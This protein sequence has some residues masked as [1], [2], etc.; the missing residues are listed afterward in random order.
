MTP[1][2]LPSGQNS[3]LLR[4]G[5]PG[6]EVAPPRASVPAADQGSRLHERRLRMLRDITAMLASNL[7]CDQVLQAITDAGRELTGAAFGAFLVKTADADEEGCRPQF[8]SGASP[9][10]F[11]RT[12]AGW[13]LTS[14][15][16]RRG[17]FRF[18]GLE[19]Q[20]RR[21]LHTSRTMVPGSSSSVA[22]FLAAPFISGAAATQGV[23]RFGHG[24]TAVFSNEADDIAMILASLAT[25]ALE[26]AALRLKAQR[27]AERNS[28]AYEAAA[29]LAAIVESSGDA[30]LSKDLNGIIQSWNKGA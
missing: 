19:A 4:E 21:S 12:W 3:S 5:A 20:A 29:Q 7:D 23:L 30:I 8:V 13:V 2:T 1:P 6:E 27:N 10:A 16:A 26:N 11:D 22:S 14:A 18:D 25:L 15:L 9:D 24:T 28:R 17:I